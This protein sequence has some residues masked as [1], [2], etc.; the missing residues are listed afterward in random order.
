M[1][2]Q[3]HR[4]GGG[5]AREYS[6]GCMWLSLAECDVGEQGGEGVAGAVHCGWTV[7]LA[8]LGLCLWSE[9]VIQGD[10][11]GCRW[12]AHQ[13]KRREAVAGQRRPRV[14]ESFLRQDGLDLVTDPSDSMWDERGKVKGGAQFPARAT[15]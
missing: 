2:Q 1:L 3:K 8:Q 10:P 4:S 12:K 5:R 7:C 9:F 14:R 11:S 6:G 13:R 15:R